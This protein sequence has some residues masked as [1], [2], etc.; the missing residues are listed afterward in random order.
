MRDIEGYLPQEHITRL[1]K[2]A[3]NPRDAFLFFVLART[4]RRISEVLPLRK[5]DIDFENGIVTFTILKK[6]NKYQKLKPVDDELLSELR[7]WTSG[8]ADDMFLFPSPH[9]PGRPITRRWA[10]RA[11]KQA[12]KNAGI[13]FVGKKPIHLHILR[14]SYAIHFLRRSRNVSLSLK[15]LQMQLEHSTLDMTSAYLQFS[16][17]DLRRELNIIFSQNQNDSEEATHGN[18]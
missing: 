17:E 15:L 9:K 3:T 2:A 5:R 11:I 8:L 18:I 12:G 7:K 6:R 13:L 16:Q 4:G 10:D 1:I 14:H